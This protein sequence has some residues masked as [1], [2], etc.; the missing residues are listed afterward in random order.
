MLKEKLKGYSLL[1]LILVLAIATSVAFMKFQDLKKEQ[2]SIQAKIVGEQIKQIGDAVNG[3]INIRYN[4]LSTLTN[5]SGS[6]PG[7]RT[8]STSN[9]TCTI[10][11]QTLV[12]E[13][14]LPSS[15]NGIN[16][17]KSAYSIILKREGNSPNYIING[18]V[19]TNNAWIEGNKVRYD[20]LGKAMQTAGMDSGISKTTSILS[21]Y[22][23]SWSENSTDYN[24]INKVGV[25]GY[26]VGYDSAMYSVYLRRDGTLPM[27]GDLDMG[28]KNI[29]N[30]NNITASG[31]GNFGGNIATNGLSS[32]DLPSGWQGLRTND[33]VAGG[34]IGVKKNGTAAT[35]GDMAVYFNQYGNLYASNSINSL[36][37][38]SATTTITA[39]GEVIAHNGYGDQISIG[40]DKVANDFDIKI[41][42][43]DYL[44]FLSA[45]RVPITVGVNGQLLVRPPSS[46]SSNSN[47]IVINSS[48]GSITTTGRIATNGLN[49]NE[50][51]PG[52]GAGGLRTIDV[53]AT[54][55]F[56]SIQTGTS[57]SEGKYAFYARQDGNVSASGN[58]TAA[59]IMKADNFQPTSTATVGG[60][61]NYSGAIS[62]DSSGFTLSCQ[63][64]K[65][66][67]QF[68]PTVT[69]RDDGVWAANSDHQA[70][71]S[72]EVIV[73]GGGQC[74]DPSH[75]F[76]HFSGPSGNGWSIDCFYTDPKYQDLGSRVYA[77]CMKK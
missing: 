50:I 35:D 38:I 5:F 28:T 73:G 41:S 12:N 56:Y 1:E 61:C 76:I 22:S 9:N 65:W 69:M 63:S 18:I 32:S 23:G 40:G 68:N 44:G 3:Y 36:G 58:I 72:D 21:G 7:P 45:D 10:T 6:D 26:R 66:Q 16:A 71:N 52:F 14:L 57:I 24:N 19:T 8:C 67:K 70:C 20:L 74:E 60:S 75:H 25:L 62:R 77:L 4:A 29:K 54:G 2:E 30:A 11:Y 46:D 51:P 55:S 27:T 49:P 64:G 31:T 15:F 43:K 37:T 17:N 39:G 33:I 34:T 47:R 13:G 53:V 42:G 48:D 59:G